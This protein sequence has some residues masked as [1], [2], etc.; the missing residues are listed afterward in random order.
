MDRFNKI[1]LAISGLLLL[2]AGW[3]VK[4]AIVAN[5]KFEKKYHQL[6]LLADKSSTLQAKQRYISEFVEALENGVKNGE[7]AGH[8]AIFL[9]TPN[10]EFQRNLEAVRTLATRLSEIQNM[11]SSSFQYN[12][13]I[14]QITAQEQG[15]AGALMTVIQGC[16]D[17]ENY[18]MVWGWIC[19]SMVLFEIVVALALLTGWVMNN[20]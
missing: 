6:W 9:K 3:Q 4:T 8:N 14:Q 15:E 17:L 2:V 7:F 12:T 10:N 11:D 16:Y 18:P 19:A 1:I 5:Y 20:D 13:A